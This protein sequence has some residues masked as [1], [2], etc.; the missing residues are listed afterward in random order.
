VYRTR[1]LTTEE[2]LYPVAL[3][4]LM[5]R[6]HSVHE[7]RVALEKRC[8]DELLVRRVMDRLK[9]GKMLDDARYAKEFVRLRAVYRKQGRFRI[10][11]DLRA[12]GVPDR[13]IEAALEAVFAETDEGE[14]LRK[15]LQSKLR[16]LRGPLDMRKRASLYNSMMRAGFSGEAVRRALKELAAEEADVPAPDAEA[17]DAA[18]ADFE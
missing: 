18:D 5:R 13:H 4:A 17:A 7:M 3:R 6:G 11:R 2:E 9:Q 14:L 16:L 8:D 12:R 10:A 1:K 15:R